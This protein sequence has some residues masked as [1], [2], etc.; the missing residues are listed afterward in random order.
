MQ[1]LFSRIGE[2][3]REIPVVQH[4]EFA[5]AYDLR[6]LTT[7]IDPEFFRGGLDRVRTALDAG[8]LPIV[9]SAAELV[10][11]RRG[12][13]LSRP[14]AI[15][16]VGMNYAAHAAESG[17]EPPTEPVIFFKHPNTLVGSQDPI[18]LPLGSKALDWE[19]E[20]GIVIGRRARY[21]KSPEE[22]AAHIAGYV[23][24]HDVSERDWQIV[25]SGGQWSKGKT[26]ETFN[27]LGP[28]IRTADEVAANALRLRS[29]VNGEPRQDSSTGDLIFNVNRIVYE[30]SQFMVLDPGDLVN[31]GTPEGVGLSGRFPYL[32]VGD[33]VEC[34]IEGLGRQRQVVI[35]APV[36]ER[37]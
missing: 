25:R 10:R 8:D 23:V 1:M 6:P 13:P 7:D 20:L 18:F 16:C 33:V 36:E 21:L 2:P 28:V 9:G 19:V 32:A 30:L 22:A 29:W 14:G 12:A 24:S 4:D 17:A 5:P 27:P 31:S 34:E 35:A 37:S 26:F 15:I 3:G 11:E